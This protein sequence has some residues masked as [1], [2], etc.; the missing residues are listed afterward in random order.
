MNRMQYRLMLREEIEARERMKSFTAL[1]GWAAFMAGCVVL[2]LLCSCTIVKHPTAGYYGSV[3][4]D[5]SRLNADASGFS[6][7]SNSNSAAFRD[8]IKQV[9]LSWQSYLVA[10]GLKFISGRYYD[11]EGKVVE[12]ATTIK[13]EEIRAEEAKAAAQTSLEALKLTTP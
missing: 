8:V 7:D 11:H 2:A 1:L 13:L 4:G 3:G 6:F 12:N 9:R 10:E 5:T